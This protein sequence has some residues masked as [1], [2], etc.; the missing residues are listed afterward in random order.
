MCK[1]KKVAEGERE[2]EVEV[3]LGLVGA[4]MVL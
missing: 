4:F 2:R 1:K 3:L